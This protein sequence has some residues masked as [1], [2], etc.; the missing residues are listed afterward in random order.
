MQF[1]V[2][3]N[4]NRGSATVYPF[5]LDIQS[6]LLSGLPTRLVI[7]LQA[8]QGDPIEIPAR[9]CPSFTVKGQRVSLVGYQAAPISRRLLKKPVASLASQAHEIIAAMDAVI[10]GV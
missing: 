2:H 7:P 4:P 8:T 6:N 5:V 10:S 1:D 9:L 3:P